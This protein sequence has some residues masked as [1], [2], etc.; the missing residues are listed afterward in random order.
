MGAVELFFGAAGWTLVALGL[1]SC[2]IPHCFRRGVVVMLAGDLCLFLGIVMP[3]TFMG[4]AF[5][6][7][8]YGLSKTGYHACGIAIAAIL[9]LLFIGPGA[10]KAWR[11]RG[12]ADDDAAEDEPA[13]DQEGAPS[14]SADASQSRA[15]PSLFSKV[16][17]SAAARSEK[18]KAYEKADQELSE[19]PREDENPGI[20]EEPALSLHAGDGHQTH[21]EP[22][23]PRAEL[24]SGLGR[25]D[26][27]L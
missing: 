9:Y 15:D 26:R 25:G 21:A 23:D 27:P 3:R 13:R 6:S 16:R 8:A 17:Q 7:G 5:F 19:S 10:V 1:A 2:L 12:G 11:R 22:R 18:E 24:F 14:N 20:R 4:M